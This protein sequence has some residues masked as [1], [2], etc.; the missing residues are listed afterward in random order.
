M[1]RIAG[2]RSR[3][4]SRAE[5]R[6]RLAH[7]CRLKRRSERTRIARSGSLDRAIQPALSAAPDRRKSE[8]PIPR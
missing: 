2:G 1:A 4:E 3:A 7:K 6:A 5:P 8:T